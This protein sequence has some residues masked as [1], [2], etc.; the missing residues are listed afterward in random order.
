MRENYVPTAPALSRSTTE[1]KSLVRGVVR[2][3]RRRG[4]KSRN[5][6]REKSSGT[7]DSSSRSARERKRG[8]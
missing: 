8:E 4:V 7:R 3:P 1:R 6:S 2:D 5:V